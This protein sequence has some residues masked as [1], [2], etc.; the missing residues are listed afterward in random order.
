MESKKNSVSVIEGLYDVHFYLALL[1]SY[2]DS[3]SNN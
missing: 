3:L 2:E 1:F